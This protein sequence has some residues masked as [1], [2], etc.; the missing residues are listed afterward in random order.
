MCVFVFVHVY[1]CVCVCVRVFVCVCMCVCACMCARVGACVCVCVRDH[2]ARR[3]QFVEQVDIH[4]QVDTCLQ[5]KSQSAAK[6]K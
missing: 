4:L 1:L 6:L 3:G 2:G 5:K